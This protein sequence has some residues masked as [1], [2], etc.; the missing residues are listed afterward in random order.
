MENYIESQIQE[1]Q[2]WKNEAPSV[3]S[4]AVGYL[5]KPVT[6]VVSKV[7]PQKAIEGAL[8]ACN[9]M[10]ELITDSKDILRDG[11]VAKISELQAKDLHL[12]DNLANN[13]HNW[14]I[15]I[16]AGEGAVAG[17]TGIGGI[18]A[19]IPALIT[20]S[21]RTI[22]KIGLCYGFECKSEQDK[23]FVLGILSIAGANTLTEKTTSLALLQ[24]INIMIA[25]NTWKS[26]TE[27][28]M[29]NKYG[30]EAAI[31]TIRSVA[32][33]LG[34]NITRR[35]AAQAI[36]IIGGAVGAAINTA[37]INDIAWAARRSFQERWLLVNNMVAQNKQ[38]E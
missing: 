14:A 18:V 11:E 5:F 32:N 26:L 3:V 33:Q 37:F 9:G 25:R 6:W 17:V 19:D 23:Q 30:V 36:P 22:H 16:A 21:F 24:K 35:K 29:T 1:I 34:I 15:G 13:V 27:K 7:V 10:A 4:K 8:I 12:S 38:Q 2:E 28:A 20:M 31:I